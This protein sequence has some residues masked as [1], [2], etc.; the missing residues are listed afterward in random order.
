M[1]EW[2]FPATVPGWLTCEEGVALAELAEGKKVLEIGSYQ[3][4][5][6]ICMAQTAESVFALDHHEGD[7]CTDAQRNEDAPDNTLASIST[8]L[9]EWDVTDKVTL[10]VGDSQAVCPTLKDGAFDLCFVDGSHDGCSVYHDV[11]QALRL[12]RV[13]GVIALH[14]WHEDAVRAGAQSA[15]L[16]GTPD[17]TAHTLAWFTVPEVHVPP[18]VEPAVDVR[19]CV[20]AMPI[21]QTGAYSAPLARFFQN[22]AR[23]VGCVAMQSGGSLLGQQFNLLWTRAQNFRR[24][25]PRVTYFAMLHADIEPDAAFWVDVLIGELEAHDADVVS[26]VVPIKTQ[27]GY[28][29][30]AMD[31]PG[32]RWVPRRRLT[33]REVHKL[34]PTFSAD[35]V[36]AMLG[37]EEAGPGCLLVNTGCWVCRLDRRWVEYAYFTINDRVVRM[38]DGD[39]SVEVEPEDWH[40]SRLLGR[41]G[42]KV[43]ATRKVGLTHHG[44]G[45]FTND[46]PWGKEQDDATLA[47]PRDR[48]EVAGLSSW[49]ARV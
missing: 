11:T 7:I 30:T 4:K 38:P 16:G 39:L 23:T 29:S 42:A 6:T 48:S 27:D 35:D 19:L 18:P 41:F 17:G 3:G 36:R 37:E 5:S 49:L 2:K 40:L 13:G 10:L 24:R 20:L 14:D 45:G 43:L 9:A 47:Y 26:A 1:A 33:M 46:Q 12:V 22:P 34:P 28:T 44:S 25:D 32:D 15:G 31:E 21:Y 8:H